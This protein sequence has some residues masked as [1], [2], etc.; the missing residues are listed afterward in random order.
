[1]EGMMGF[2]MGLMSLLGG[3]GMQGFQQ[4]FDKAGMGG[5]DLQSL[6]GGPT[7]PM[8]WQ[9]GTRTIPGGTPEHW[10]YNLFNRSR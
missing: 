7:S 5:L 2:P 3:G 10:L 6:L 4:M 9:A 1:M 8:S